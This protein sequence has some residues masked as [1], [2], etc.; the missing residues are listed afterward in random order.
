MERRVSQLVCIAGL[1]FTSIS[2]TCGGRHNDW[3]G[4]VC[5]LVWG[6]YIVVCVHHKVKPKEIKE[7]DPVCELV[8]DTVKA[9]SHDGLHAFL[10]KR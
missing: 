8:P 10:V 2:H 4:T 1:M 6:T 3:S 5:P 9:Q 7:A